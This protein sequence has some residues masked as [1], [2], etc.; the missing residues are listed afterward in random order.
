MTSLRRTLLTLT[1]LILV[2]SL[3][4]A[5]DPPPAQWL[6]LDPLPGEMAL[7]PRE[8]FDGVPSRFVLLT[9]GSVF[10][11]GRRE[12]LKGWLDKGE[13]QAISTRLDAAMKSLGKAGPP[14]TLVVG[15]G[16]AIFRFS[17]LL[18]APIQLVVM[19]DLD[20][21]AGP[22]LAPLPDFIR[23]LAAF[24]HPSLKPWDPDRFT[25]IVKERV[26]RGGCRLAPALGP[27]ASRVANDS[28]VGEALT[29]GFPTG[30]EMSQVCDG[31]KR[32]TVVFRP[33][34][35]GER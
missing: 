26:L 33:L 21:L 15:E 12:V 24:R 2:G 6:R 27:L 9:D 19:G 7:T 10:V 35:P 34:I 3:S 20:P 8:S 1:P 25:L 32:Y 18:G 4:L 5:Q 17:V 28:A 29:H 23:G 16:P 11:G 13:M 31:L 30:S 22:A 14:Q